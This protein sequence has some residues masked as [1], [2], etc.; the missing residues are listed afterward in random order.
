MILKITISLVIILVIF[1]GYVS[2]RSSEFDYVRSGVIKASPEEIFPYI[3][4]LRKGELWSPYEKLDPNMKKTFNGVD[5]TVGSSMDFEGN[6]DAGSGRLEIMNIVPNQ[7]VELKLTMTEPIKV[8]NVVIYTLTSENDGTRFSWSMKGD[9]GFLG[10]L[11]GVFIDCEKM[12]AGQF[13]EGIENLKNYI[14]KNKAQ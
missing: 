10:K 7:S 8:E 12:L 1:L 5:G 4:N 9:S 6:R 2:T 14:E 11:V 13:S 3:S